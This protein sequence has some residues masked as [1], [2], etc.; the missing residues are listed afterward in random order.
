MTTRTF[1][2]H[3]L[4]SPPQVPA[5]SP[6]S[7]GFFIRRGVSRSRDP[8]VSKWNALPFLPAGWPALE[9][10]SSSDLQTAIDSSGPA[11]ASETPHKITKQPAGTV[12]PEATSA[13]LPSATD[14]RW[15]ARQSERSKVP[16]SLLVTSHLPPGGQALNLQLHCFS[17]AP[18][19]NPA[20]LCHS[21]PRV[22]GLRARPD[23]P[24][25]DSNTCAIVWQH[26]VHQ[27]QPAGRCPRQ[28]CGAGCWFG[29]ARHR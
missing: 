21:E 25:T 10:G 26:H 29:P 11:A 13:P 5:A 16:A 8:V 27:R 17:W 9:P 1:H 20:C 4:I 7:P 3:K 2:K 23:S 6:A 12:T 19:A 18:A 28:C 15:E 14:P 22:P 24:S